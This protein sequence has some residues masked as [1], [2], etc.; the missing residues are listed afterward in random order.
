MKVLFAAD[1]A[2]FELKK[3]LKDHVR[4]LG[5]SVED[6]GAETLEPGDDYAEY[7]M[8]AATALA[9][10]DE[11]ARA[12]VIGGSGQGEAMIMNR[13][14]HVRACVYY[15]GGDV[16]D[17]EHMVVVSR[18]DN[19]SNVLSLGA[20]FVTEEEALRAVTL[21]LREPFSGADRHVRRNETLGLIG[22]Q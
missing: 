19:D 2:G 12:I 22:E 14:A 1:H 16:A 7:C 17:G 21:W 6:M 5:H 10:F 9:D 15:G 8:R 18:R 20:R 13:Y 4:A 3:V 11:T